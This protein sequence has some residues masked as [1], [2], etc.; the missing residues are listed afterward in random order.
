MASNDE[1]A[2]RRK[3]SEAAKNPSCVGAVPAPGHLG[4]LTFVRRC[5]FQSWPNEH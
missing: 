4:A 1:E 2:R 5:R 3:R